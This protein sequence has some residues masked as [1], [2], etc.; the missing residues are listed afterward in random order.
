MYHFH[1]DW[2]IALKQFDNL[3]QELSLLIFSPS[4]SISELYRAVTGLGKGPDSIPETGWAPFK[5][6]ER[7]GGYDQTT[8]FRMMITPPRSFYG[9]T[10]VALLNPCGYSHVS[11]RGA[12]DESGEALAYVNGIPTQGIDRNHNF[13]ILTEKMP[14]GA[15]FDIVLECCPSTRFD[16]S[17]VFVQADIAVM[18]KEVWDLYWDGRV[19]ADVVRCHPEDSGCKQRLAMTL[20]E[21]F[22]RVDLRHPLSKAFF[23]SVREARRQLQKGL[24][25]F[26]AETHSGAITLIGHSHID[27]AW[28]WPIR[29]TKRKVGRTFATVLKLMD[30]YPE[31]HF[32]A[33][34]PELYMFVKENYPHL[35]RGIKRRAR[36]GRWEP[37]GAT[38]VEQ[39]S[40]M[41]S[42]ES[43]IRH[44]LYGNRFFEREFGQRSQV[45][46]LPDAFGFPW[47]LPQLLVKSGIETFHTIK[48]SWNQYTKFPFSYFWWQGIDGS[49]IRAVMTPLNYNGD[50]TPENCNTQWNEFK[51]KHVV[52]EVPMSFGFGDGGGGPTPKMIEYGKRLTN[53]AG[54]PKCTFGRT[55]DCFKRMQTQAPATS[56]PVY[57]GELYLE[58]HRGCQTTQAR[59][60]RNNRKC[61]QLLHMTELISALAFLHGHPYDQETITQAWRIL[62][63]HQFHDIL[64]GSSITEVYTDGDKNYAAIHDML[65]LVLRKAQHH[66]CNCIQIADKGLPIVVWNP[67]SW[68]R[69]DV[70]RVTA[71]LPEG[72]VHVV[73]STGA[74]WPS[75]RISRDELLLLAKDVPAMGYTVCYIMQGAVAEELSTE[76]KALPRSLENQFI[77][78]VLDEYGRF[79]RVYDKRNDREVLAPGCRGNEL[80]LFD[81]RPAAN[82]A[83]DIEFN[84]EGLQWEPGKATVQ[85]VVET[86]PV[87]A[88][89]RVIRE[90]ERSRFQQDIT[91]YAHSE[92]IEV[93]TFIE[94]Y[95]KRCLLKVAFPVNILSSKATYHIQFGTIERATHRNTAFDH[96]RFEVPAQFWSDLSE[97]DYGVSLLNDC[98]YG[99]DVHDNV[100]RLSLLRSPIDPDPKA[101][102]GTHEFMYALLPHVGD[103]RTCTMREAYAFNAPLM[104]YVATPA[105]GALPSAQ[106]FCEIS[107]P[108]I[109]LETVKKAEDSTLL[110]LRF[111]E[112]YGNRGTASVRFT[113]PIT[114]VQLC[115]LMEDK[116][117]FLAIENGD[118]IH[119]TF[120]P[121]EIKS[122]LVEFQSAS[123]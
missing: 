47:S 59:T 111:Y 116:G 3:L 109:I 73:D 1:A 119:L 6:M 23:D 45:A 34:Q 123:S 118:T 107:L 62:L 21:T 84:F 65:A 18:N 105:M 67:L 110:V 56:L 61:E 76:L 113:Q 108:N 44:L 58:L 29:E 82:D 79:R 94:W 89:V 14:E 66:I 63:T 83:W 71:E 87:R 100:L 90:T 25:G 32:S 69:T 86:G 20:L 30:E 24:K 41:S 46:W 60:K 13:I 75:Q 39:D 40:N 52:K 97:G 28:L 106:G 54:V 9:K 57:N 78:V 101:D 64:P 15:T 104:A 42:G 12:H 19:Y 26:P 16:A 11:G 88:V 22:K 95:E 5:L 85:E 53:I 121:Y 27:T 81:D 36:E 48:I 103:W 33:S 72:D 91:L 115:N 37:C 4:E 49:R 38:W 122:L 99:Y 80:Q 2:A 68:V 92:R 70:V 43:L 114:S 98:K 93:N 51:Q 7:W 10:V 17:H 102:E 35:W 50:P 117:E 55:E 8:W 77:K 74:L 120:T 96:A 31:F 112:A